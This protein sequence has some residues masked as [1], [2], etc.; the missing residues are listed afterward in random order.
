MATL[1]CTNPDCNWTGYEDAL[2]SSEI[3]PNSFTHCP[4]CEGTDFDEED[5]ED[6]EDED[7]EE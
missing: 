3:E 2:V 4:Y 5:E 7:T 6:E 1:T